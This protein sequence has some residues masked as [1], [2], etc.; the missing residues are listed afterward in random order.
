[1]T[2]DI[3]TPAQIGEITACTDT[4]APP[5]KG[6]PTAYFIFGTNQMIA[7]EIAA[8]KHRLGTAPLIIATGGINRHNSITEGHEF[9]RVLT[10]SGVPD[11]A[12]RVEDQ[13]ANTWQNVENALPYLKEALGSGLTVTAVCKWYHRRAVCILK[14]VV[15]GITPF[16]VITFDP[17]YE[18]QPVTRA[19]WPGIASG[20]RRVIREREE[21]RR[22]VADGSLQDAV[23]I[24]GAWQ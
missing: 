9:H 17:V 8:E 23:R 14:T 3:L 6:Q 20:R 22:R 19:T 21:V 10:S 11:E 24:D 5:P 12:I 18:D 4:A 1:L 16:H 13:S 15:P 7:A 2:S